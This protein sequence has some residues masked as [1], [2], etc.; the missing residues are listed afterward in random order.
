MT[1][2]GVQCSSMYI[3]R[4]SDRE[5]VELPLRQLLVSQ[6]GV[7]AAGGERDEARQRFPLQ[8]LQRRTAARGQVGEAVAQPER[9]H[10]RH[11][12]ASRHLLTDEALRA[13]I[14]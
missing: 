14:K 12:V 5:R 6:A 7:L 1:Q 11:R 10:R 3:L 2:R 13:V 4:I 8:Q 9:L